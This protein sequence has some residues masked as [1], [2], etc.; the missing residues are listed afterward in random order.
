MYK[1]KIARAR[2]PRILG[3]NQTEKLY[4]EILNTRKASGEIDAWWYEG[5]TLKLAGDCRYTPD[6]FILL[7]NGEG[8][9]H[10]TKGA[11]IRDDAKVKLKVAAAQ[12]PFRFYLCQF[13]NRE[14]TITEV[15][16]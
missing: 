6:F 10:E 3:M 8:E 2:K 7:S 9:F 13:K 11:Y 1:K 12:F 4:S 5:V 15:G 16:A 14:W